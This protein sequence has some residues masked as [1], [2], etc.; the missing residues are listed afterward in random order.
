MNAIIYK[1]LLLSTFLIPCTAVSQQTISGVVSARET[2]RPIAEV[3]FRNIDNEIVAVSGKDGAFEIKHPIK[4]DSVLLSHVAF[5]S[6]WML[7]SSRDSNH[8]YLDAKENELEEVQI[9]TGYFMVPKD[10]ATGSFASVSERQLNQTAG[11]DIISRLEGITS[12]LNF[13]RRTAGQSYD[14][15]LRIRGLSTIDAEQDPLIIL[16]NFPFHGSIE[17]INPNDVASVTVLKD[18]AA[19]SIWGARAGNG[20]IVINTKRGKIQQPFNVSIS[21][22]SKFIEKPNL[23]YNPYFMPSASFIDV[24]EMLFAR[25]FYNNNDVYKRPLTPIVE[26]LFELQQQLIDGSAYDAFKASLQNNDIRNEVNRYLHQTGYEQQYFVSLSGGSERM[27]NLVSFGYDRNMGNTRRDDFS[28]ATVSVKNTYRITPYLELLTNLNYFHSRTRDAGIAYGDLVPQGKMAVY[29]YAALVDGSGNAAAIAK[30]HRLDYAGQAESLGLLNWE[31]RPLDEMGRTR[32]QQLRPEYRINIGLNVRPIKDVSV[33]L[34]YEEQGQHTELETIYEAD[35]YFARNEVNRFTQTDGNRIIPMGGIRQGSST[36]GASR[37]ARVNAS[38]EA[39][40]AAVHDVSIV[41]GWEISQRKE[42]NLPGSILYGFDRDLGI[43]QTMLDYTVRHPTL[44]FGNAL[45]SQP[46]AYYNERYDRY[47]SYYFNGGYLFRG[48]YNLSVSARKDMSNLFGVNQNQKGVPLWSVG[49]A[50]NVARE[51]FFD[52]ALVSGLRLR[53]TYG[54]SGNVDKSSTAFTTANYY[55]SSLTGLNYAQ[56]IT[57]PNPNL[58]W[59]KVNT[60]NLG[61]DFGIWDN[62]WQGSVEWYAKSGVDLMGFTELDPTGGFLENYRVN[63]AN[64]K[65]HGVDVSL[66]GAVIDRGFKWNV[67]LLASWVKDRITNYTDEPR[68][69]TMV[70]ASTAALLDR[71]RYALYSYPWHGL[72]A[73]TGDPLVKV[74]EELSTDYVA[75]NSGL[76]IPDMV[77]HGPAMPTFFGNFRNRFSYRQFAVSIN[78]GWKTGFYYRSPSISYGELFNSWRGH[79]DFDKR[80]QKPGD[81]QFTDVPSMPTGNFS[82]LRDVIYLGSEALVQRG[83]HIRIHDMLLEYTVDDGRKWSWLQHAR[84]FVHAKNLGILWRSN[85]DGIDPDVPFSAIPP[86]LHLSFGIQL[87]L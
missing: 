28:R 25:D 16:D 62:R 83:D 7:L 2:R 43:G 8:I 17:S 84:I 22:T 59:E 44:P 18:A 72:D 10:R 67:M 64:L 4:A 66:N 9:S 19:S 42:T 13:D 38:Y 82:Y 85:P 68:P 40:F 46:P 71:P 70:G 79:R 29:P 69:Q 53:A 23:G 55:T 78:L 6:K 54:S 60:T 5:R 20:V 14:L 26:K 63:Y 32:S 77:Y 12:G 74:N 39:S 61:L 31:Y 86:Q 65:T 36:K 15:R 52:A 75:F 41:A 47:L 49:V 50:W 35:A 76:S 30:N 27:T 1:F 58:R 57:P 56:I 37:F 24:E 87:T 45:V 48:K 3:T 73:D 51:G 33:A 80:W 34:M 21:A 11:T 81:E